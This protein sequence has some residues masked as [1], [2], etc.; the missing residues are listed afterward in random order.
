MKT[1]LFFA[2]FLLP[3]SLVHAE[4]S[5]PPF[6]LEIVSSKS[7]KDPQI[8][9]LDKPVDFNVVLTNSSGKPQ[10][11]W[12]YAYSWGYQNIS[13]EFTMSDGK[14]FLISKLPQGFTRNG[15]STFL[16][17]PGGHQEYVI[18]FDKEWA[19]TPDFTQKGETPVLLK[20]IYTVPN[21]DDSSNFRVWAGRIES[22][23]YKVLLSQ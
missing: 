7:S 12:D 22:K 19:T 4:D 6:T 10:P 3:L 1:L 20:A 21:D 23:E 9:A 17:P 14:K 13:F 16:I 15:Q 2:F 8:I 11:I 18:R 5:K